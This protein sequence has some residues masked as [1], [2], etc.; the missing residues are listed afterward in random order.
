MFG[1]V[2]PESYLGLPQTQRPEVI[3][4]MVDGNEATITFV[5]N[6]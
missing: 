5:S 2:E 6:P 1:S 4:L 3:V